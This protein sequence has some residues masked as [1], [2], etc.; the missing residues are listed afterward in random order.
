MKKHEQ[1]LQTKLLQTG[2]EEKCLGVD[3]QLQELNR[4]ELGT[5]FS[6]RDCIW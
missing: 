3:K 1:I 4:K 5:V 6:W 2:T